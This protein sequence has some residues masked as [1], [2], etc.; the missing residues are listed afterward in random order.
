MVR[1]YRRKRG[2]SKRRLSYR[3]RTRAAALLGVERLEPRWV[4]STNVLSYHMDAQ[5]TGVNN[6]ETLLTPGNVNTTTFAKTFST[7][8]DGQAYAEPLYV[9]GLNITTGNFQGVHN[10]VFAAT[11][12]DGLYAI[13]SMGGNVLWYDSFLNPALG[14]G[15]AGATSITSVPNGEVNSNDINPEIG[16]TG[17][18]T[19]DLSQN[20]LF[21]ITKT[22]QIV[23]VGTVNHTH[24]VATLFKINIQNGAVIASHIIGDTD[25]TNGAYTY[26]TQTSASDPNQDPFVFGNGSGAITLP[27]QTQSRVYFNALRQMSRPGI[28][29]F[30]GQIYTEWASHGDNGPYHGWVLRFDENTLA[31]TAALNTTPNGG[32]GGIWQGGDIMTMDPH[33][34]AS[35]NPLFY[36][37]TGNGTFDG[38]YSGTSPNGTTTGLNAQGFPVNGDYGDSFVKIGFDTTTQANQNINGWGLKVVDYFS[39][40]NNHTLDGGDTDL[41]SGGTTI[42]PDSVGSA[43]HP[44]LLIGT[45]KEGKIY[46][47]DRDN[48]GKFDPNNVVTD[49][50]VEEQHE[51]SGDLNAAAYFNNTIY[52][53]PGYNNDTAKT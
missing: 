11:E 10:T 9:S 16:I 41:G 2:N 31:L 5:S 47:I 1:S 28:L 20:A 19:I 27:G 37:M 50:V 17:T 38:N 24:Y 12:H 32:L 23:P 26:R 43:A 44:H 29:L 6:T 4:L 15:I 39:P 42:L 46:L 45:G 25:F 52:Y 40:Q 8:L 53:V 3:Q 36:F 13:D 51:L 14:A 21:V 34:D 22:K 18:P 33:L 35:G 48:M 7:P 49:A 30:N